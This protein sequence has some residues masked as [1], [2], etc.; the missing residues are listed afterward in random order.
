M[1]I[2]S[3]TQKEIFNAFH[4]RFES[5]YNANHTAD[6]QIDLKQQY[7]VANIITKICSMSS[8]DANN[9]IEYLFKQQL[10]TTATLEQAI[11]DLASD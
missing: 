11:I 2:K 7:D 3:P 10:F 5:E 4:A 8:F 1:S 9:L 6:R